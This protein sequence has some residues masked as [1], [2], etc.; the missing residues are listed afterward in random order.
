[1]NTIQL[2]LTEK[3]LDATIAALTKAATSASNELGPEQALEYLDEVD[4][5]IELYE[6]VRVQVSPSGHDNGMGRG[7]R[8]QS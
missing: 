1:M 7:Q 8:E 6:R 5:L 4:D 2:T 3:Q